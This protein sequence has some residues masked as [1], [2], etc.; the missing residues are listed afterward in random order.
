MA[1][2]TKLRWRTRDITVY[3]RL[4]GTPV[5]GAH[6]VLARKQ[7]CF[8]VLAVHPLEIVEC[9]V[10]DVDKPEQW[11]VVFGSPLGSPNQFKRWAITH[12]YSGM[13]VSAGSS[14]WGFPSKYNARKVAEHLYR[15]FRDM[16]ESLPKTATPDELTAAMRNHPQVDDF[17]ERKRYLELKYSG[18]QRVTA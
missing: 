11:E 10:K 9:I 2:K 17:L 4:P 14:K 18:H 3:T 6:Q 7:R 8:G 15:E 12:R 5:E 16:L 13:R 1:P